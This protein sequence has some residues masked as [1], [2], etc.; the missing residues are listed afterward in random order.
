MNEAH[1]RGVKRSPL[2]RGLA[3]AAAALLAAVPLTAV[4]C[5]QGSLQPGPDVVFT[6]IPVAITT[7][8]AD[9]P[10]MA[11]RG[12]FS[13]SSTTYAV[14]E[15]FRGTAT[16]TQVVASQIYFPTGSGQISS[17]AASPAPELVLAD[18]LADGTLVPAQCAIYNATVDAVPGHGYSPAPDPTASRWPWYAGS[19]GGV[20]LLGLYG[21]SLIAVE[22]R[23][24]AEMRGVRR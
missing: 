23:R 10:G 3:A 2:R 14:T 11:S 16:R 8:P 20:I 19:V 17:L 18:R 4:A 1:T 12:Y 9:P 15:V 7:V 5:P 22:R 24:R 13:T 21:A 6:G